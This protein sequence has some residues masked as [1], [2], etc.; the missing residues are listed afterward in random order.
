MLALFGI[1]WTTSIL[2]SAAPV[3]SVPNGGP[4]G[5]V[6]YATNKNINPASA[7]MPQARRTPDNVQPLAR[8]KDRCCAVRED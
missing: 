7:P 2:L 8:S 5:R 3:E 4:S 6:I 1:W